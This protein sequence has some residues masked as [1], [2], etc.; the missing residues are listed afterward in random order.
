MALVQ[1]TREESAL[2]KMAAAVEGAVYLEG[3]TRVGLAQGMRQGV[4]VAWD[5]DDVNAICH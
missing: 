2:P 3:I 4:R 5:S 1:G